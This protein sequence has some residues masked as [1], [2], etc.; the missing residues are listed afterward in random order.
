MARRAEPRRAGT[1]SALDEISPRKPAEFDPIKGVVLQDW[2][3]AVV[4]EH[5]IAEVRR[6]GSGYTVEA[7]SAAP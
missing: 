1:R 4:T 3:D 2:K 7:G 5:R 6:L